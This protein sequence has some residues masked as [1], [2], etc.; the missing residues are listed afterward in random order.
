MICFSIHLIETPIT[1]FNIVE[2]RWMKWS[3][4]MRRFLAS[5]VEIEYVINQTLYCVPTAG[6]EYLFSLK[7]RRLKYNSN[8]LSFSFKERPSRF[9][10]QNQRK[11]HDLAVEHLVTSAC[12]VKTSLNNRTVQKNKER[13]VECSKLSYSPFDNQNVCID[14]RV[15]VNKSGFQPLRMRPRLKWL[16]IT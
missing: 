15:N 9:L 11:F 8:M 4:R 13:R 7:Y 1:V 16:E 14:F 5:L 12:P 6:V 2:A 10:L 3:E